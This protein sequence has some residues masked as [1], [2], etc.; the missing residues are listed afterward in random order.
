MRIM[1]FDAEARRR[2]RE[3]ENRAAGG[4]AADL[5]DGLGGWS[6]VILDA[7]DCGW[8]GIWKRVKIRGKIPD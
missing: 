3:R 1:L 7:H 5:I 6:S 4:I 2:A 8:A